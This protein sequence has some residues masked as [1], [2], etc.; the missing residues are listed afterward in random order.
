MKT[1][2]V[3]YNELLDVGCFSHTLN[4]MGERMNT[5]EQLKNNWMTGSF[6]GMLRVG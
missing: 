5:P 3:V 2:K 4:H 1:I 6:I